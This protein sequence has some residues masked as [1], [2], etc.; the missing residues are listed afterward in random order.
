MVQAIGSGKVRVTSWNGQTHDYSQSS[1]CRRC[2][3]ILSCSQWRVFSQRLHL[4]CIDR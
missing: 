2:V 3:D 4:S 1:N